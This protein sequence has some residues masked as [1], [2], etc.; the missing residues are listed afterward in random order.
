MTCNLTHPM[1]LRHPVCITQYKYI[2]VT[3]THVTHVHVTRFHTH[4]IHTCPMAHR[5]IHIAFTCAQWLTDSFMSHSHVLNDL[6]I[7][8]HRIHMCFMSYDADYDTD[9]YTS[10]SHVL[11]DLHIYT[12]RIH[13][14]SMTYRFIHIAF[15]CA[16]C[17][18]T[19]IVSQIHTHRIHMFI[20][21]VVFICL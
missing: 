5:F 3:H 9:S 13:M 1:G 11:N 16:Q 10:H 20:G 15:I 8:T 19:Q 4:D 7:H 2:R 14:C 6:Q 21:K 18:M 12:C 17:L